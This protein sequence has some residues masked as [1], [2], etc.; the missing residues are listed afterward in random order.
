MGNI[1]N[2]TIHL[3]L[4]LEQEINNYLILNHVPS[5]WV[6]LSVSR[7]WDHASCKRIYK[8]AGDRLLDTKVNWIYLWIWKEQFSNPE[9]YDL[10][11]DKL[12]S[13]YNCN[14]LGW[15][16]VPFIYR[17]KKLSCRGPICCFLF[18]WREMKLIWHP[19]YIC[20]HCVSV[21]LGQNILA[22]NVH[23]TWVKLQLTWQ[24]KTFTKTMILRSNHINLVLPKGN[25]D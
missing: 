8:D 21:S 20:M 2:T 9:C 13:K 5:L 15:K 14:T 25:Y 17:K 12:L 22:Q 23:D 19:N 3:T 11:L 16:T 7:K 6:Q 10:N 1:T 4:T 24:N 18:I